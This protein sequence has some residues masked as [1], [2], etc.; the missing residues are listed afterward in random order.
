V[1]KVELGNLFQEGPTW[2]KYA[3]LDPIRK[4]NR[5]PRG[6]SRTFG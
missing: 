4:S 6:Y 5:I 1:L 3:E 2:A